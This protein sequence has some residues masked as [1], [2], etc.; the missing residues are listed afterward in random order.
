MDNGKNLIKNILQKRRIY[1]EI[2][3]FYQLS[4]IYVEDKSVF[5]K[6]KIPLQVMHLLVAYLQFRLDK[7]LEDTSLTQFEVGNILTKFYQ[8]KL[9]DPIFE[10][11]DGKNVVAGVDIEV[12]DNISDAYTADNQLH[13]I[14]LYENW[15]MW[16]AFYDDILS[17]S[18]FDVIGL[19]SELEQIAKQI[20]ARQ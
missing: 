7:I 1:D 15:E 2:D 19:Q 5:I 20:E 13:N 4:H 12:Y 14:E 9:V 6:T 16:C 8:S 18:F 10:V 11:K 3:H 17:L